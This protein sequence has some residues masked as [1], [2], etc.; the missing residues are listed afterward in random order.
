MKLLELAYKFTLFLIGLTIYDN[1]G[2]IVINMNLI[3]VLLDPTKS[4]SF[5]NINFF[6]RY[7]K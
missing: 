4:T 1:C 2:E 5:R 7:Y 3:F 6:S